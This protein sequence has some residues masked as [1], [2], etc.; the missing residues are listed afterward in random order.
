MQRDDAARHEQRRSERKAALA[1]R[2]VEV[3]AA[4]RQEEAGRAERRRDEAERAEAERRATAARAFEIYQDVRAWAARLRDTVPTVDR[5]A[6]EREA[7]RRVAPLWDADSGTIAELRRWGGLLT[8]TRAEEYA[9]LSPE[10]LLRLKQEYRV[11]RQQV[12]DGLFVEESPALGGFGFRRAGRLVNED[13]L[14]CFGAL[15]ALDDAAV[16]PAFR[17]PG[18]RRL[19]WEIGGGWGGFAFQFTRLCRGVTYVIT[20]PPELFLVSAV[21]LSTVMPGARCRFFDERDPGRVWDGWDETDFVFVPDGVLADFAPPRVDLT[22]D[23]GSLQ[24]MTADRVRQ[25]ARRAFE[26][27]CRYVFSVLPADT[28]P[29]DRARVWG[30][31]EPC[32]WLHPVP[33]RAE[34]MPA[35][36]EHGPVVVPDV[37][38][39]H[40]AG[41]RRL[42]A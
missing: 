3:A 41:W 31:L 1:A 42:H 40:V 18:P 24:F 17:A 34:T 20:A 33:P 29:D 38:L 6:A 39:T 30:G 36:S 14:T 16:L 8:G 9:A 35:V 5:T 10:S 15:A 23:L 7:L 2:R 25:H 12:G 19:V 21:Y 22:L 37:R 11:L 4:K 28:P 27:G 13:T 26:L 32:Y